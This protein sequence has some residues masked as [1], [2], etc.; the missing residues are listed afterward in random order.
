MTYDTVNGMQHL[1][2][3]QKLLMQFLEMLYKAVSPM[4]D[5]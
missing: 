2:K 4:N 3:R 1:R 5:L